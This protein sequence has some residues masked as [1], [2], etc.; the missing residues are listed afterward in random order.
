MIV[1][2]YILPALRVA[3]TKELIQKHGLKKVDVAEKMDVT[4]AA[5]THYM[6]SSRGDSALAMIERS[7]QTTELLSEIANDIAIGESP[8]DV[9]LYKMC[10]ACQMIRSEGLICEL[11][12]EVM[13][14]LSKIETCACSLGLAGW[15]K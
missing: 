4:P 8:A 9:L 5:I 1:V 3:I 15:V 10:K 6:K 2:Q 12:R 7:I 14:S 11:H 13:P